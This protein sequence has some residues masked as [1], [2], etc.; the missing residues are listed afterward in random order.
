MCENHACMAA[1]PLKVLGLIG[2]FL[3]FAFIARRPAARLP[4]IFP[5][6]GHRPAPLAWYYW[7]YKIFLFS[8]TFFSRSLAM[9]PNLLLCC[10]Q[11]SRL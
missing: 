7:P 4:C 3:H 1:S 8:G 5:Q 11:C 10:V 2:H 6:Q 9:H